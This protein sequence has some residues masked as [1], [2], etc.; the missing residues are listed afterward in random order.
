MGYIPAA[1]LQARQVRTQALPQDSAHFVQQWGGQ[2]SGHNGSVFHGGNM[3][4]P[5]QVVKAGGGALP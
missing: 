4:L 5:Q 3:A 2:G 1:G